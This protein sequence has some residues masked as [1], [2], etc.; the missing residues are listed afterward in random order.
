[1]TRPGDWTQVSR[2]IGEHSNTLTARPV[3][4]KK[5]LKKKEIK[6]RKKE[7]KKE[8]M[9]GETFLMFF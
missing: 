6:E 4:E 9:K 2:A 7:R 3:F 5:Y 1:M 8:R